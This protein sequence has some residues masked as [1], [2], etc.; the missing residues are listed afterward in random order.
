[1]AFQSRPGRFFLFAP[2][3][4]LTFSDKCD[5]L[6]GRKRPQGLSRK[7]RPVNVPRHP[8][9]IQRMLDARVKKL[10]ARGPVLL[11][12]LVRIAKH[13]GRPGCRCQRGF[14]HVGNYLTFKRSGK[15]KTVY[16]P[17]D[18]V[19]EVRGW[20]AETRRLRLLMR[21]SSELAVAL[22]AGHVQAKRRR[23]TRC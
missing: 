23:G 17:L 1:M 14:K 10:S 6:S 21:E 2:A 12:S 15:T 11:A 8:T 16:V 22:V 18:M 4:F 9:L 5:S 3:I 7:E 20:I 19:Q 13:C